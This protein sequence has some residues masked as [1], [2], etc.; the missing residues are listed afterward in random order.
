ME[1]SVLLFWKKCEAMAGIE[2]ISMNS[3]RLMDER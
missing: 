2:Y 3:I 1:W